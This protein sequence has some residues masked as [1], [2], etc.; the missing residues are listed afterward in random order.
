MDEVE[1]VV[2]KRS[3][4]ERAHFETRQ[5]LLAGVDVAGSKRLLNEMATN[6]DAYPGSFEWR[7][8]Q[9]LEKVKSQGALQGVG[10]DVEVIAT[11]EDRAIIW[12]FRNDRYFE[13]EYEISDAN[14]ITIGSVKEMEP[15]LV[16][17]G[18]EEQLRHFFR[19]LL[20]EGDSRK[21]KGIVKIARHLVEFGTGDAD[22]AATH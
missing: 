12:D 21:A 6:P 22:E 3:P 13:V 1:L 19:A 10:E 17:K 11:Y 2:E 9:I 14:G 7:A 18:Q 15:K 5:R 8:A 4:K 16:V 20:S